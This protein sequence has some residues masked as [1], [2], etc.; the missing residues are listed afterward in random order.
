MKRIAFITMILMIPVLSFAQ[1]DDIPLDESLIIKLA[2]TASGG[3]LSKLDLKKASTLE[4]NEREAVVIS[5]EYICD[6]EGYK[7]N[8][9]NE[10]PQLNDQILGHLNSLKIGTKVSFENIRVDNASGEV[11]AKPLYLTIKS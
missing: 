9:H 1:S 10:G 11:I 2:K 3:Y 4:V 6:K 5:F 7:V 8:I